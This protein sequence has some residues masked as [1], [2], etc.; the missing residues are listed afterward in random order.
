MRLVGNFVINTG[1]GSGGGGIAWE[2]CSR[3]WNFGTIPV[4]ALG[5]R[6]VTSEE[7]EWDGLKNAICGSRSASRGTLRRNYEDQLLLLFGEIMDIYW[8]AHTETMKHIMG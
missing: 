7:P 1:V 6:K 8:Q 5:T 4:F 3:M 2:E